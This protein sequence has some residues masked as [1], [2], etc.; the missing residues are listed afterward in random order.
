MGASSDRWMPLFIEK[1]ETATK[2]LSLAEDGAYMRLIRDYWVNGPPPDDDADLARILRVDRRE[3]LKIRPRIAHFFEIRDGQWFHDTVERELSRAREIIEKR[4]GAGAAGAEGRWGGE[5]RVEGSRSQRL[6]AARAIAAHTQDEWL[7]LV[8]V[9]GNRCVRC[10]T[11][12][13]EL[14]GAALCKDHIRPI[15]KGGSD[16]I[17]NLQP[18][19]RNCNAS[20]GGDCTDHR[21]S[22]W[23]ILLAKRLANGRQTS[24]PLPLPTTVVAFPES[25]EKA[26]TQQSGQAARP[27]GVRI[28]PDWSPSADNLAYAVTE[29]FTEPECKRMAENFRDYWLAASGQAGAKLDWSATWRRWVRTER[30]RRGSPSGT[31]RRQ[32]FV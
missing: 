2:R 3:W 21:Q 16:G 18:L 23:Q 13:A 5:G 27:K 12:A 24:G 32:G 30:D 14:H 26:E 15:F 10:G 11:A 20:R 6:A 17:D 4:K 28:K 29:G 1:Y 7:A 9:L 8:E 22:D 25:P 19:C 31:P